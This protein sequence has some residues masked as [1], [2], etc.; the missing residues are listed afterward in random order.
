MVGV[1]HCIL[2]QVSAQH[3]CGFNWTR[4][5][6][7]Q[8]LFLTFYFQRSTQ[9]SQVKTTRLPNMLS[10]LG[11]MCACSRALLFQVVASLQSEWSLHCAS[12]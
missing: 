11:I 6:G 3:Q 12:M 4:V 8:Q 7:G 5:G 10:V 2:H 9:G 1:A